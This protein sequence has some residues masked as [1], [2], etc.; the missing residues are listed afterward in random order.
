[1]KN[2]ELSEV[3]YEFLPADLLPEDAAD[4]IDQIFMTDQFIRVL[5]IDIYNHEWLLTNECDDDEK[6]LNPHKIHKLLRKFQAL[7]SLESDICC[8]VTYKYKEEKR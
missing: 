4:I 3:A 6:Q 2:I 5:P 8:Y 1:M 7:I